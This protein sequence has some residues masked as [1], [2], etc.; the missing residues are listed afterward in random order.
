[1]IPM[2][3][4]SCGRRGT[5]PPDRLH[6]RM[7]CK[8]CDAVF[9][10]DQSGKIVLGDPDDLKRKKQPKQ[11]KKQSTD[12]LDLGFGDLVKKIPKPVQGTIVVVALLVVAYAMGLRLPKFGT[13]IPKELLG[14][15][16]FVGDAFADEQT[17]LLNKIAAPGTEGDIAQWYEK[18]R[19]SFKFTGPQG[20][21]NVVMMTATVAKEDRTS[22]EAEV[23]IHL[24]PP[25]KPEK[26]PEVVAQEKA[27]PNQRKPKTALG[28]NADGSFDLPTFWSLSND[29]WVLD[30]TKTLNALSESGTSKPKS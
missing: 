29:M 5:V 7:H 17:S 27:K 30:G 13:S 9:Y 26:P 20:P 23:I 3:C 28:Y 22:G 18:A 16:Q 6:T 10:M 21:G 15:A 1:M 4:P 25:P 19:P 11:A 24:L 12:V 14:R 2:S 8:K